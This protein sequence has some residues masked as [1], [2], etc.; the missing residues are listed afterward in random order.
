MQL[1]K[2]KAGQPSVF[3]LHQIFMVLQPA[4]ARSSEEPSAEQHSRVATYPHTCVA[5]DA[6]QRTVSKTGQMRHFCL[7]NIEWDTFVSYHFFSDT[8]HF[9]YWQTPLFWNTV[10]LMIR[11]LHRIYSFLS[12]QSGAVARLTPIS[13][14]NQLCWGRSLILVGCGTLQLGGIAWPWNAP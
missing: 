9:F 12:R 10:F 13:W 8:S 11:Q 1:V 6:T 4:P 14:S 7:T 2:E 5:V 3:E